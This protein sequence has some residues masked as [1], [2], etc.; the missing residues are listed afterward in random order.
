MFDGQECCGRRKSA[1]TYL[2]LK[3]CFKQK[4]PWA[5]AAATKEAE[6]AAVVGLETVIKE[7]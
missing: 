3:Q 4:N 2:G 1:R 5:K 6:E 7:T